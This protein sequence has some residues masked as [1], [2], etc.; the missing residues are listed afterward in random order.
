MLHFLFSGTLDAKSSLQSDFGD[1]WTR[2]IDSWHDCGS[3]LVVRIFNQLF[4]FAEISAFKDSKSRLRS[5]I[6][7]LFVPTPFSEKDQTW[8]ALLSDQRDSGSYHVHLALLSETFHPHL[9]WLLSGRHCIPVVCE[10][11]PVRWSRLETP[12]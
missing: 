5:G 10:T 8:R 4:F 11:R 1:L 7:A 9:P 12:T 6:G 3:P 2:G